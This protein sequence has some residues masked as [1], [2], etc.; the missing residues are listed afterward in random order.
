MNEELINA[1]ILSLESFKTD[2]YKS[3]D[4]FNRTN[5]FIKDNKYLIQE[6]NVMKSDIDDLKKKD[7]LS[8]AFKR[9]L[10]I[11]IFSFGGAGILVPVIIEVL[12]KI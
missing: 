4:K 12:K 1:R 11:A 9:N 8:T 10:M 5:D 7:E 3:I 6:L 2:A